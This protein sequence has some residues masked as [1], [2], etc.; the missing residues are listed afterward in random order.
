M[1]NVGVT[2][3]KLLFFSAFVCYLP[4]TLKVMRTGF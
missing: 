1:L 2:A 4:R 3:Y